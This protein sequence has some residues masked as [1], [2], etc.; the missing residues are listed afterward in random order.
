[1]EQVT[2]LTFQIMNA[3]GSTTVGCTISMPGNTPQVTAVVVDWEFVM[4]GS[5]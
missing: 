5:P 1:M 2:Q 4:L 3:T